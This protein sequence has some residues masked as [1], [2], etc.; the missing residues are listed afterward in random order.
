VGKFGDLDQIAVEFE[1]NQ[2]FVLAQVLGDD[3]M[4]GVG[5]LPSKMG[6]AIRKIS[7]DF[8]SGSGHKHKVG[9]RPRTPERRPALYM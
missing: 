8:Y 9:R 1:T 5:I 7:P 4:N 6:K 2:M 3:A